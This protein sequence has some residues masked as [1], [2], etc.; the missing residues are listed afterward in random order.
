LLG[1]VAVGLSVSEGA[2]LG[3]LAA[4][5]L[6]IL[7]SRSWKRWLAA[8]LLLLAL[9][10]VIP[11][12]RNYL[13]TLAT[14]QDTSGDVRL[15][16]WGGTV[17]LLKAHPIE[18]AGLG[19]FPALYDQYRDAAHVELPVYPHNV[20]L[21]TWVELGLVG[22]LIF[23]ALVVRFYSSVARAYRRGDELIRAVSIGLLMAMTALLVHGLVDVPYFK[24]DLAVLFWFLLI[25]GEAIWSGQKIEKA[26]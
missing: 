9:L 25:A 4:T 22:L 10:A 20:L 21:N 12:T 5:L 26:L 13:T 16:M 6:C 11:Q 3:L 8:G 2:I 19:G 15:R 1:L 23:V 14:F 7:M 17:R 24:N 18:G